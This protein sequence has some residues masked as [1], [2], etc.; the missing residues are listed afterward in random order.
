MSIQTHDIRSKKVDYRLYTSGDELVR[1]R[2]WDRG[3]WVEMTIYEATEVACRPEV[4]RRLQVNLL[5]FRRGS[6]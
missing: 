3:E 2:R 6:D 5:S 1:G 4:E